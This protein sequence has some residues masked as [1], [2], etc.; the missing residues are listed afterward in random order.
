MEYLGSC[1]R[2]NTA[3]RGNQKVSVRDSM[4]WDGDMSLYDL[5][6]KL[7]W[8]IFSVSPNHRWDYQWQG[9]A[10]LCQ[11]G[12]AI[13]WEFF[14][15]F[16]TFSMTKGLRK[17]I[18]PILSFFRAVVL[19]NGT[20]WPIAF[21]FDSTTAWESII[22]VF[23]YLKAPTPLLLPDLIPWLTYCVRKAA[24]NNQ[25]TY[26]ENHHGK[27]TN[28][29]L[30]KRRQR[31]PCWYSCS[32]P[33]MWETGSP[34]GMWLGNRRSRLTRREVTMIG[35]ILTTAI[36]GY[37]INSCVAKVNTYATCKV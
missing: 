16:Q 20:M 25:A 30:Y 19:I 6:V 9:V 21:C 23:A 12:G 31:R 3:F 5:Y 27:Y 2:G 8:N 33:R 17:G 26:E 36:L 10:A 28:W 15:S 34:S 13:F 37:Y 18:N 24:T 14:W 11:Q 35:I 7:S 32:E 22:I 29:R 1:C 4:W